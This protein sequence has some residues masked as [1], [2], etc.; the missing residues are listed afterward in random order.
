M[1]YWYITEL[2]ETIECSLLIKISEQTH[3]NRIPT[4]KGMRG[5]ML[6]VKFLTAGSGENMYDV[7]TANPTNTV[8]SHYNEL[9]GTIQSCLL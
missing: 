4:Q 6:A 9:I 7:I 2:L 5:A 3:A 1:K 8:D